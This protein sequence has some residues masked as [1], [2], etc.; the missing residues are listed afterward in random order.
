MFIREV[1]GVK[2]N[3]IGIDMYFKRH[4]HLHPRQFWGV[5]LLAGGGKG[6]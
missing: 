1:W 3:T 5:G 6:G 4:S 2:L